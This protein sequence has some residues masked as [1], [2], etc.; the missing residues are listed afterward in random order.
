MGSQWAASDACGPL[1]A[2][3]T[4]PKRNPDGVLD[5]VSDRPAASL[6]SRQQQVERFLTFFCEQ[7]VAQHVRKRHA[8]SSPRPM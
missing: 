2:A 1:A 8:T 6:M 5:L 7:N 3:T 4:C